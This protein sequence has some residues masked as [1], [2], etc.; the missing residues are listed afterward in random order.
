[1]PR[2]QGWT[3]FLAH[4]TPD[5]ELALSAMRTVLQACDRS[6][7]VN[8]DLLEL[9]RCAPRFL[10]CPCPVLCAFPVLCLLPC[11]MPLPC[12]VLLPYTVPLPS[13]CALV[14]SHHLLATLVHHSHSHGHSHSH[15]AHHSEQSVPTLLDTACLL[16]WSLGHVLY[17]IVVLLPCALLSCNRVSFELLASLTSWQRL[18]PP[19]AAWFVSTAWNKAPLLLKFQRQVEAREWMK[20]ALEFCHLAPPLQDARKGMMREALADVERDLKAEAVPSSME[21]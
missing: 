5:M 15:K 2:G 13:D 6:S 16:L 18:E 4:P 7:S 1:M 12:T 14:F 20:L 8:N 19:D 21:E 10:S 3:C 9:Y 17:P 11:S